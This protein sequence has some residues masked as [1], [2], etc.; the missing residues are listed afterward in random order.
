MVV[1]ILW[2]LHHFYGV[3]AVVAILVLDVHKNDSYNVGFRIDLCSSSAD[4]L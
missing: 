4:C 3:F 2:V 1:K